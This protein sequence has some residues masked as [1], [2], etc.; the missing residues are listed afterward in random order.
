M[1]SDRDSPDDLT[2]ELRAI[3]GAAMHGPDKERLGETLSRLRSKVVALEADEDRLRTALQF[4]LGAPFTHA[5]EDP[6]PH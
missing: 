3:D 4:A 1:E 6:E 2:H 5:V